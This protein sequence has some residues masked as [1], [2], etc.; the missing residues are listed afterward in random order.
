MNKTTCEMINDL[1]PLYADNVCSEDSRTI[2]AEHITHCDN[3]RG[4]LNKMNRHLDV[5]PENDI[6]VIKRI[7]R[8]IIIEKVIIT[9]AVSI[10]IAVAVI[11]LGAL[12]FTTDC[13]MCY[14]E[15][16]DNI[17][18]EERSNGDLWMKRSD[19]ACNSWYVLPN[20]Y[21]SQWRSLQDEGYDRTDVKYYSCTLRQ[22]LSDKLFNNVLFT[23][24]EYT[25][26]FN[27]NEKENIDSVYYYD[28]NHN[29][30]YL[31]WER[32]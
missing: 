12:V 7:K 3:C 27:I 28:D 5:N 9:A 29:E 8:R 32:S 17:V 13:S 31:L 14:N 1:L 30:K 11:L 18:V 4:L 15:I 23:Q 2:V 25:F 24:E 19:I 22:R 16:Q 6:A 21:D 26:L 10:F 20:I